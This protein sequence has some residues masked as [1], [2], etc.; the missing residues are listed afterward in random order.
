MYVLGATLSPV[1]EMQI[2][3]RDLGYL[4]SSDLDGVFG[5]T[6]MTAVIKLGTDAVND[7]AG[8]LNAGG[9]NADA[10]QIG[11]GAMRGA[12]SKLQSAIGS[13]GRYAN[14]SAA[15]TAVQDA[16]SKLKKAWADWIR[17]GGRPATDRAAKFTSMV[18]SKSGGSSS[19]SG[20]RSGGTSTALPPVL[21]PPEESMLPSFSLSSPKVIIGVGVGAAA[22]LLLVVAMSGKKSPSPA[23]A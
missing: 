5:K 22:L 16:Q 18:I 20:S 9:G 6:T 15:F 3:L 21:P 12:Q 2:T 17:A 19:S 7:F 13:D 1:L 14:T 23:I 8:S 10:R 11:T 4:K